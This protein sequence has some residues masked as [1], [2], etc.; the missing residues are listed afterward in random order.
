MQRKGATVIP[1]H[2]LAIGTMACS[3]LFL[4][5]YYYFPAQWVLWSMRC[6][7]IP[8]LA[9]VSWTGDQSHSEG[10]QS[11]SP[12]FSQTGEVLLV[13]PFKPNTSAK[14]LTGFFLLANAKKAQRGGRNQENQSRVRWGAGGNQTC[15]GQ[16]R[17]KQVF[18]CCLDNQVKYRAQLHGT[19]APC[20]GPLDL[21]VDFFH[22]E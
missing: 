3:F 20:R 11:S 14:D 21:P 18:V 2:S 6:P 19:A 12:P 4:F 8:S 5:N 22:P 13:W 15:V 9:H 10:S 1:F 16:H 17:A 7:R